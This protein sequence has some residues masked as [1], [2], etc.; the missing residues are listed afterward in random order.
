MV[1]GG[2][3]FESHPT[4]FLKGSAVAKLDEKIEQFLDANLPGPGTVDE[5]VGRF[6]EERATMIPPRMTINRLSK[7]RRKSEEIS[8]QLANPTKC[9]T[10]G[11]VLSGRCAK[12][13]V[14]SVGRDWQGRDLGGEA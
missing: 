6:L 12:C 3:G 11:R 10:C 2:R 5:R 14:D 13:E 7:F 1:P 8:A 4:R 9:P